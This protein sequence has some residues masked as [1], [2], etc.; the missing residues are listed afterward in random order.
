MGNQF[1]GSGEAPASFPAGFPRVSWRS[2]MTIPPAKKRGSIS[3]TRSFR[4][5]SMSTSQFLFIKKKNWEKKKKLASELWSH[6]D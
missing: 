6:N 1:D 5:E 4:E 2:W 3:G